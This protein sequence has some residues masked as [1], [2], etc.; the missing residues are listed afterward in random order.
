MNWEPL[1][2][3]STLNP[4]SGV[5]DAVTL[6]LTILNTSDDNAERGISNNPAPLPLN[7]DA[8]I[9]PEKFD[10]DANTSNPLFGET[11]A[12]TLPLNI[13]DVSKLES[14][15]IGISNRFLP[16]PL[17]EPEFK[18][19]PAPLINKLPVNWV[20]FSIDSI[21]NPTLGDTDA[22]TLPD[23]INVDNNASGVNAVL[24]MLNNF[25]PL[26][27]KNEPDPNEIFPLTNKLPV[28]P[29]PPIIVEPKL[30]EVTINPEFGS[31]DAVTE[32]ETIAVAI[33]G[34]TTIPV[35]LLP[36]PWNEPLIS[37]PLIWLAIIIFAL[38]L[39]LTSTDDVNWEPYITDPLISVLSVS[40]LKP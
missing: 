40:T 27:L 22:V 2:N 19:T 29:S 24:G 7:T 10:V 33:G 21:L 31:T 1:C 36:S 28:I 12:V 15:E 39:P 6:P 38:R 13:L 25:S 35:N 4:N 26:P 11:D 8:D 37:E 5:T 16:L 3:D 14:A 34:G 32:P 17:N 18:N 20:P 30:V 9:E 23:A